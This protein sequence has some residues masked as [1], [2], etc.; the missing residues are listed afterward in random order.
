MAKPLPVAEIKHRLTKLRNYEYVLYPAARSRIVKLENE[1]KDLQAEKAQWLED[2]EQFLSLAQ[3]LQLQ[4]EMLNAKVFGKKRSKHGGHGDNSD[5]TGGSSPDE[6]STSKLPRSAA[7]YRR[8]VPGDDEITAT[9]DHPLDSSDASPH[10]GHTL[11]QQK[12]IDYFEEDVILPSEVSLKTVSKHRVEAAYCQSCNI[13]IYGT[14]IPQQQVILGANLPK[15]VSFLSVVARFSYQQ[16]TEHVSLFYHIKLTDGLITNMLEKQAAKLRPAYETLIESILRQSGVHF[17][18]STWKMLI[19]KLGHY[20]W[21]MTGTDNRDAAF[22]FGQSRGKGVLDKMLEP[23][24]KTGKKIIGI[25]DDY[26]A[27]RI[28]EQFLAHALCWAH[29]NRKLRDLA[30][31]K[32]LPDTTKAHCT[33]VYQ[34]F[35]AMYQEVNRLWCADISDAARAKQ[36]KLLEA[37]FKKIAKPHS[38]D[39]PELVTYKD[40]LRANRDAYFVCLRY[41]NIP[42]DNNKAE[43]ALR[44]LVIKRKACGGSKTQKGADVL[45]VLYSVLLSL[46]WRQPQDYFK[47]YDKLLELAAA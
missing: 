44:H 7:S 27:Y 23:L 20:V 19:E 42:P 37:R 43:R 41:P 8:A 18:E 1:V 30:E 47:E 13:W 39:P 32:T 17:D 28:V 35:N 10:A 9:T 3:K 21:V 31:S 45:S 15:L 26:G 11:S 2:R 16:I 46:H 6:S 38:K 29:P 12:T 14:D 22:F 34:Q 25:S 36:R 33:L 24:K 4:V 40:S 5:P